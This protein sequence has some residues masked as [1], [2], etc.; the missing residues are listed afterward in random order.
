MRAKP[1]RVM[2]L[3]IAAAILLAATVIALAVGFGGPAP[4]A[5]LDSINA[6][7]RNLDYSAIPA[8]QRYTARDG[9]ALAYRHYASAA[10]ATP[11][12]TTTQRHIVLVHGS[13]ASSRS[14]H[15]MAQALVAAGYTVDALDVRGHGDSG[16]RGQI[17][18]IGQLEDDLADFMR[19]VPYPGP[20]TLIGFS[21]GAGFAL[22]F[23]ASP[24]A[25]LFDRYVLLA[26]FL[27]QAPSNRPGGGGW[28]SVG[29]PRIIALTVLNKIGIT[30]WN[31]LPVTQFALNAEARKFLT[32]SYSYAL[33]ANFST[34]LDYAQ[35][36]RRA[37]NALKLIAG[38]DD[39][40]MLPERYAPIFASAGKTLAI[41]LVPGANHIGLTLNAPALSAVVAACQD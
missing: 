28:A 7:F 25:G 18:Y 34:H 36:I 24:Q 11:G 3:L 27:V 26:P 6:P 29:L 33:A 14:M 10:A 13:S 38:L 41:T 35:D 31:D 40:L 21:A 37:P 15:P 5:A 17:A 22:R 8:V 4:V 12:A 1:L 32:A 23:A 19:A 30:A 20:S 16:T 9:A 39:E 2:A